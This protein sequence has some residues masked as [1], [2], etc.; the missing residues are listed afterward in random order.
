MQ[1]LAPGD[2]F[3]I[4]ALPHPLSP[5]RQKR[6]KNQIFTRKNA[7]FRSF[8]RQFVISRTPSHTLSPGDKINALL[9]LHVSQT[10]I[11]NNNMKTSASG[12]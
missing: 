4:A 11:K 9:I 3:Q 12:N 2:N 5:K 6:K 8:W 1:I 10:Q 7:N